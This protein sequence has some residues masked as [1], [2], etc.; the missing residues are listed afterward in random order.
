MRRRLVSLLPI[1]L[2][3]GCDMVVLDPSGDIAAQQ[4]DLLVIATGLMLLIIIPVMVLTVLFAWRYSAQRGQ[5]P[6]IPTGTI[7]PAS[8][9]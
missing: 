8:S 1:T 9:W 3:A 2:L 7:R 6:T 4:R 5:R